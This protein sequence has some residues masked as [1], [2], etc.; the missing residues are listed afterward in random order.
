MKKYLGI[1]L[2]L[3]C[4]LGLTMQVGAK[5]VLSY[6]FDNADNIKVVTNTLGEGGNAVIEDG[7]LKLNSSYAVSLG[8]VE[9]CY[10]VTAMAKVT[11]SG[12][13][14]TLVFKNMGDA[15]DQKWNGF[16]FDNGIPTVWIQGDG[17]A[18]NK[19]I[20][21][22]DAAMS[23]WVHIAYVENNGTAHLYIDGEK[24]G[25]GEVVKGKG[26]LY[27]GATLWAGDAI[28]A[29]VDNLR[30]FDH[31]LSEEEVR[32]AHEEN[33]EYY[34]NVPEIAIGDINLT[35]KVG[36]ADIVWI[37]S[38][39]DVISGDGKVNRAD[40]DKNVKLS[41]FVD[42][43]IVADFDV[44]VLKKTEKINDKVILSYDFKDIDNEIIRDKSGNGND[45]VAHNG[46]TIGEDG[47]IFDG[48]DDYVEM[49][50]GT[51]NGHDEITIT[52]TIKPDGAQ[53]HVALYTFG[54]G[55][56]DGYMFLNPS[57]P[58]TNYLRFATTKTN[59]EG[60]VEIAS[61]PG[62]RHNEWATVT[63]VIKGA[64]AEMYLNGELVMDGDMGMTVSDLGETKFNYIAKSLY[65]AD[66]YFKGIVSEFTIYEYAMTSDEIAKLYKKDVKYADATPTGFGAAFELKNNEIVCNKNYSGGMLIISGY[67]GEGKLAK[68]YCKA[69]DLKIGDV[70]EVDE[71]FMF[72]VFKITYW[73]NSEE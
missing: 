21:A 11:S 56:E 30:V 65:T 72:N 23:K 12:S 53:K 3:I 24:I 8:E 69:V 71:S 28:D 4:L 61:I 33:I 6:S 68:V 14:E 50:Q 19:T 66:P 17:H 73:G 51:L 49:V 5:E 40:T 70:I 47:A 10:S 13:F 1:I 18:H 20:V 45:A 29:N 26:Q 52:A 36:T 59:A 34:I 37:S 54:N 48:K 57:R 46:L 55:V 16:K 60:E 44:L 7:T 64:K 15:T 22:N 27:F 63:V 35:K 43:E 25:E 41:A 9:D 32:D 67:D 39:N 31:A 58:G 42:D 62:V 2:S 38:D